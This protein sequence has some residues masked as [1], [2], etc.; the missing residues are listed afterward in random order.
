VVFVDTPGLGSPAT[1]G[2]A[3]TLA[4]LPSCDLGV[5][6]LDAGSTLNQEDLATLQDLSQAVILA[7]VALS[8]ADRLAD[9]A[10]QRVVDYTRAQI[11][12]QLGLQLAVHR[13]SAH[14]EHASLI[15]RW[16]ECETRPLCDRHQELA[17]RSVRL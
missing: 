16:F 13:V 3:E 5:V 9:G 14:G 2:A 12:S 10:R 8:K 11:A 1:A 15:D 7:L 6:L 17:Q 4:Y